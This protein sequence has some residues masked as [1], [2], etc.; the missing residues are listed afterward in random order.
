M[1]KFFVLFSLVFLSSCG[2]KKSYQDLPNVAGISEVDTVRTKISDTHFS[3]GKNNLFQNKYGVWELYIEGDALELGLANGALTQDLIHHQENAFMGKINEM[4]PSEG[5]RNFLKKLVSWFNRKMYLY[6]PE[7]YKQEIYGVSRFGLTKYDEFAP[8]YLRMLYFHGAHDIGH[9]LQDLMLVGCTSFAA[10]DDK[11]ADGELLLG[12]NF[13][14]YAGDEFSNQKMVAFV[15]PD[16]GHKFMMYTW[17]GMIGA[18]SGMNEEG[19][20]VTINAGKSKIPMLAKD[21]ITLVSREILQHASNL[22]DAIEIARKREVFVSE[23]I[24]IG[25]AK[26]HKAILIEVSPKNF[27]VYKVEN[28]DQLIC[29]NHFQSSAYQDDKRNQ[30]TIKESHTQYRYERMTQLVSEADKLTPKKAVEILRNRRGLNGENIGYGNEKAI[31]QLLAHH[32]IVFKPE[33][34]KVWLSAN[35][36]QMGAFISYDLEN[37]FAEFEKGNVSGSVMN[38][39]EVIPESDFLQTKNYK[40][41]EEYRKIRESFV[42]DLKHENPIN[43]DDAEALKQLNPYFWQAYYLSGQYYYREGNYKK[44]II[45]FKQALR[46]EISTLPEKEHLKKLLKKSYRKL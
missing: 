27:G 7:E 2:I 39:E 8:A 13:D 21:P 41:Y 3:L 36:Y 17:G 12:R 19:I 37:V 24:M 11:T 32:G 46:R 18:V 10:W 29:S 23:S 31:N 44:A 40:N 30:K 25:S 4:V 35:P 1:K 5:Y 28:S 20:T 26:D 43:P 45:D 34:K 38:A 9:A 22:E 14:F 6:V 15:N 16:D 42:Q 33:E